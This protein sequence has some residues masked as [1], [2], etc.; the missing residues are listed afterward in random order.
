MEEKL[1]IAVQNVRPGFDPR[2]DNIYMV[3]MYWT[4][5]SICMQSEYQYPKSNN[6]S[7]RACAGI[8]GD[9]WIRRTEGDAQILRS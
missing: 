2:G 1:N 3:I 5:S 6:V 8:E 7:V 4:L 9:V